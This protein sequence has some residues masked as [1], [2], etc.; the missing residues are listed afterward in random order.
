MGLDPFFFLLF[1]ALAIAFSLVVVLKKSPVTSAFSLVMVFF[2]FAGIYA[3]M[4]A[5][6]IATFQILVYAGAIM[7]LFI[8]V[9]MLLKADE[10]SLDIVRTSHFFRGAVLVACT[11][12]AVLLVKSFHDQPETV[13]KGL[14][15]AEKIQAAGGNSRAVSQL[16]FSDYLLPFELTSVLLLAA[17]VGS[18]SIAKRRPKNG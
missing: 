9:I 14:H 3:L 10:P 2:C 5:H 13:Q 11:A 6:L 1:A 15:T 17:I 18:V 7:V 12:L 8:F 16:I 4:G